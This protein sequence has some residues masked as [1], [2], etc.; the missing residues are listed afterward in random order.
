[1]NHIYLNKYS[2]CFRACFCISINL[3]FSLLF[4]CLFIWT[5]LL[6]YF[7]SSM[8]SWYASQRNF[9][10]QCITESL[11]QRLESKGDPQTLLSAMICYI[12]AGSLERCVSCW[13]KTR[14]STNKPQDLQV[15]IIALQL[16]GYW[17]MCMRQTSTSVFAYISELFSA[18][19]RQTTLFCWSLCCVT[20]L[21][22]DHHGTTAVTLLC[23]SHGQSE[24]R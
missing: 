20:G 18:D 12:C 7:S 10:L 24:W 23:W 5:C 11:G 15:T 9:I 3:Y 17:C 6:T 14:P 22:G 16:C 19:V 2:W 21:G 1:M 13:L 4:I 8:R